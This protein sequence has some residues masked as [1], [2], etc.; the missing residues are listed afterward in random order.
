MTE[1]AIDVCDGSIGCSHWNSHI[2]KPGADREEAVSRRRVNPF[3]AMAGERYF[4]AALPDPMA[5]WE[6]L[7]ISLE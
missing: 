7:I 4:L 2:A 5:L 6:G 1:H 3:Q